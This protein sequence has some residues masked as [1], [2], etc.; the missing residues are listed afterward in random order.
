MTD[1]AAPSVPA[2][3]VNEYLRAAVQTASPAALHGMI[4]D[5][6]VRFSNTAA[7]LLADGP[8]RDEK[9]GY[10]ALD[11]AMGCVTEL[12]SG[13]NPK[14]AGFHGE[15]GEAG[16]AIAEGVAARFAFSLERLAEA[17]RTNAAAPAREAARVLA[18]HAETWR[19]LLGGTTAEGA[20][21]EDW[22]ANNEPIAFTPA[23]AP[24]A[25]PAES[26]SWAA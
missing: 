2:A 21:A 26:R 5:A 20:S 25:A 22:S 18:A 4:V 9:G 23:A 15:D 12:I 8:D 7:E 17:G 6:A 10:D 19:E 1:S 16:R 14:A 24:V 13:V 3:N 11:R